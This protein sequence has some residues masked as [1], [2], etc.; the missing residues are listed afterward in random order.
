MPVNLTSTASY[1]IGIGGFS[2][3]TLTSGNKNVAVG[4]GAGFNIN[5]GSFNTAL[6]VD[7]LYNNQSGTK[8]V[9]IG[10]FSGKNSTGSNNTFLGSDT[11]GGAFG[12]STAIGAGATITASNQIVLGTSG[13]TVVIPGTMSVTNITGNV[14]VTGNMVVSN[15]LT[16]TGTVSFPGNSIAVSA[17]N[18]LSSA[19][20]GIN[21][22][23]NVAINQTTVTTNFQLD[24]NGNLRVTGNI[25]VV[26]GNLSLPVNSIAAS[27]ISGLS[28]ALLGVNS[29]GNVAINQ[30][31][32]TPNFQLDVSGNLRVTG[33]LSLGNGSV[34]DAALTNNIPKLNATNTF[35]GTNN[36]NGNVTVA[37]NLTAPVLI[38]SATFI[39][40]SGSATGS[41]S[42]FFGTGGGN[43]RASYTGLSLGGTNVLSMPA[44]NPSAGYYTIV[45]SYS[46][47]NLTAGF[48][49]V[50]VQY[51]NTGSFH[52]IAN[53]TT[54]SGTTI[55]QSSVPNLG[56]GITDAANAFKFASGGTTIY[57]FKSMVVS[58]YYTATIP[59]SS[60]VIST[61]NFQTIINSTLIPNRG[62][63]AT[64]QQVITFGDNAP[65][66]SGANIANASIPIAALA[67][68]VSTAGINSTGNVAINTATPTVNIQLDVNG[69]LRVTGSL[70]LANTSVLDA[71]LSA[72][73]ALKNGTNTWSALNTFSAGISVTGGSVNFG[74]IAPT[75]SGGNIANNTIPISALQG[76]VSTTGINSV[77]NVAINQL[78]SAITPN[79]HF[80]VSGNARISGDTAIIGNVSAASFM[81]SSDR[82]L[83]DNI[84]PL[85]SASKTI[86]NISPVFFDWKET[87][88]R[89]CGFI[90]QNVFAELPYMNPLFADWGVDAHDPVTGECMFYKLDYSKMTPHLWAAAQELYRENAQLK[91][92]MREMEDR[93]SRIETLMRMGS[94]PL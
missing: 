68:S 34:G 6:G 53:L 60:P 8:N 16:V 36:L 27:A 35:S 43:V 38:G 47:L 75:M 65:V 23:G 12:N 33:S 26:N 51:N 94:I 66:M 67:G 57:T 13:E 71:A 1:N 81:S 40:L 2:L 18:G 21:S 78:N 3:S 76:S 9:A 61:N 24:V 4:V 31:T 28:S 54:N 15:G 69:N 59:T 19:L 90:A 32:A 46:G 5:T 50:L 93:L 84:V 79:Y 91:A 63:Y 70:S 48:G 39:A 10:H 11:S 14:Q 22:T 77:G 88:Q 7:S 73:V 44:T 56:S 49:D 83:K 41:N 87:G 20:V 74:S 80:D 30:T 64:A 58:V 92:T 52:P 55:V 86:A 62:L 89:D 45:I 37:S 25:T 42:N 85:V 29:T 17:I 72:N 82:R